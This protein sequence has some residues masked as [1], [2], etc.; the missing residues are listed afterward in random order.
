MFWHTN[1]KAPLEHVYKFDRFMNIVQPIVVLTF[2]LSICSLIV[3]TAGLIVQRSLNRL[4]NIS[5][6]A[7]SGCSTNHVC[8]HKV[9]LGGD[10]EDIYITAILTSC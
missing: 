4:V 9:A 10:P 7:R 6:Y 8:L 3:L 2:I 5:L 1:Q